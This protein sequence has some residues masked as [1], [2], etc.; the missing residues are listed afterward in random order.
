MPSTSFTCTSSYGQVLISDK[1]RNPQTRHWLPHELLWT[2]FL[3]VVSTKRMLFAQ[4][5]QDWRTHLPWLYW[6]CFTPSPYHGRGMVR[7]IWSP[8]ARWGSIWPPL[9]VWKQIYKWRKVS[10]SCLWPEISRGVYNRFTFGQLVTLK[11]HIHD[12]NALKLHETQTR[13]GL[14]PASPVS[15]P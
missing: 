6:K 7:V 2:S 9:A 4:S 13:Q 12:P 5:C 11:G 8:R 1:E 15:Y 14:V 3:P 10:V